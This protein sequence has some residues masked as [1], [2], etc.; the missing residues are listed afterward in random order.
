MDLT[1]L[2][3]LATHAGVALAAVHEAYAAIPDVV[4]LAVVVAAAD[5]QAR[6]NYLVVQH[7]VVTD[8]CT[9]AVSFIKR[10]REPLSDPALEAAYQE[11]KCF[12]YHEKG[13]V[14][15]HCPALA[16]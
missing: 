6:C 13:H 2:Q 9:K 11:G 15:K 10:K 14:V 8:K 5:V 7:V 4:T 3:F 1:D 12:K 16:L